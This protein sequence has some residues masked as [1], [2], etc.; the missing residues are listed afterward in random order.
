[1][2]FICHFGI[3]CCGNGSIRFWQNVGLSLPCYIVSYPRGR[4]LNCCICESHSFDIERFFFMKFKICAVS[5]KFQCMVT[6][7]MNAYAFTSC[8]VCY[9]VF[10]I[11]LENKPSVSLPSILISF[12]CVFSTCA[13]PHHPDIL[14][15]C[16]FNLSRW[17]TCILSTWSVWSHDERSIVCLQRN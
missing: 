14:R 7:S 10:L 3:F 8:T 16:L 9:R 17:F 12:K 6:A 13:I 1:M 2:G 4:N 5:L 15:R 11:C